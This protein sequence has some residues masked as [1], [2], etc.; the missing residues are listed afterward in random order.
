MTTDETIDLHMERLNAEIDRR[1][2]FLDVRAQEL[3]ENKLSAVYE[4][5]F[6]CSLK[7]IEHKKHVD[8]I[9]AI[10]K[11]EERIVERLYD[12]SAYLMQIQRHE[13]D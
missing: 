6:G 11:N 9:D 13:D 2:K 3:R 8:R 10:I 4:Y 5:V 1:D 12:R 7:A